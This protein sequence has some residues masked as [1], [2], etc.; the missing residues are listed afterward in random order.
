MSIQTRPAQAA[1]V[2]VETLRGLTGYNIRRASGAVQADL[3]RTLAPFSLRMITFSAL[4]LVIDNPGMRQSQLADAL[5][6]ERSNLVVVVD[7][8]EGR[9]LVTRDPTPED[10]RAY[11]LRPTQAGRRLCEKALRAVEAHEARMLRH[12]TKAEIL[13]LVQALQVV[14]RD[15]EAAGD[16][17]S[18][19][20]S[21]AHG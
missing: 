20:L 5:A 13:A 15:V 17:A 18:A 7:D 2:S 21:S 19:P 6:I 12:L 16:G 4:V 10:R 8:L 3:A 1:D 9:G 11:A 14:Q